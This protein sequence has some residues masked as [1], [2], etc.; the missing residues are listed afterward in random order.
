MHVGISSILSLK[1]LLV[2]YS[3]IINKHKKRL[4]S[5]LENQKTLGGFGFPICQ[6]SSRY[7]YL[8]SNCRLFFKKHA[9]MKN[10][11]V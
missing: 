7:V 1:I 10:L 5:I 4:I 2:E 9:L 8:L 6:L 3:L 11:Y